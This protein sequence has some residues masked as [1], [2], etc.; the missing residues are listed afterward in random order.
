MYLYELH[1]IRPDLPHELTI[2]Q[3]ANCFEYLTNVVNEVFDK[4]DARIERNNAKIRSLNDRTSA[5]KNKIDSLVGINK[6]I[7]IFSPVKYPGSALCDDILATFSILDRTE[8]KMN[9]NYTIQNKLIATMRPIEEKLQFYRVPKLPPSNPTTRSSLAGVRPF[10]CDTESINN[11]LLFNEP[12][13]LFG[14]SSMEAKTAMTQTY[15]PH[16]RSLGGAKSGSERSTAGQSHIH[17]IPLPVLNRNLSTKRHN[18]HLFYTP[19]ISR[20]PELDIPLDLPDLPGIIADDIAFNLSNLDDLLIVPNQSTAGIDLP[21]VTEIAQ[22]PST[23]TS[24]QVADTP[25]SVAVAANSGGTIKSPTVAPPPPPPPPPP[26]VLDAAVTVA[27]PPPPPPPPS[28]LAQSPTT[29]S[30]NEQQEIVKSE[31]LPKPRFEEANPHSTLMN[32]IRQAGGL[33]KAKL[34]ATSLRAE[35]QVSNLNF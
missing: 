32:A 5:V 16:Q 8:I 20:A 7:K 11:L 17:S 27:P 35:K 4:I 33:G 19:N 10:P 23:S 28:S 25:T 24:S 31:P 1:L 22:T 34:R 2:V 14:R 6:A 30:S 9:T 12:K 21:D 13:I 3:T 26:P 18:D 29:A 15:R